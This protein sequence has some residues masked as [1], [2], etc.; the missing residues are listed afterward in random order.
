LRKQAISSPKHVETG[1]GAHLFSYSVGT[2]SLTHGNKAR[3]FEVHHSL[4]SG[5]EVK[6]E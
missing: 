5:A 3:E 4:P 6:N 1:S 2:G